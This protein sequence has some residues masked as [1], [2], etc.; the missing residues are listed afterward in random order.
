MG[1]LFSNVTGLEYVSDTHG[2]DANALLLL[3]WSV[4]K[5]IFSDY[6]WF[7]FGGDEFLVLCK[8]ISERDMESRCNVLREESTKRGDSCDRCNVV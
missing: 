3:T 2:C 6:A 4:I 1:A 8:G 5:E 7:R